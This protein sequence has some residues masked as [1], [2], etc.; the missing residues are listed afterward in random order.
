MTEEMKIEERNKVESNSKRRK[1]KEWRAE[2]R[3]EKLRK[4][5][6]AVKRD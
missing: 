3:R 1:I 2:N 4:T 5:K 6:R